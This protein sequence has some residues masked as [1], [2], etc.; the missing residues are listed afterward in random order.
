MYHHGHAAQLTAFA[1]AE[2]VVSYPVTFS[3][4]LYPRVVERRHLRP[5]LDKQVSAPE[6]R[7]SGA[8]RRTLWADTARLIR[9]S[10]SGIAAS[11]A[12]DVS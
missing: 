8:A 2:S 7:L 10:V 11:H 6:E 12:L 1:C 9:V 4:L 3:S 5:G